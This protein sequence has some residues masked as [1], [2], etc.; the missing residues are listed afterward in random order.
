MMKPFDKFE[1]NIGMELQ[2]MAIEG[3]LDL[4]LK[5][6]LQQSHYLLV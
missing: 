5:A 6:Y 1:T 2:E 3:I 4:I